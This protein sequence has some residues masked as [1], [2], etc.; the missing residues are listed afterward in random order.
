[1]PDIS[2][3]LLIAIIV[4]AMGLFISGK[5]RVDIIAL[6]VLLALLLLGLIRTDQALHGFTNPATATI[7]AIFIVS[8]GLARTGLIG[9]VGRH[10]DRL[11]GKGESRLILVLCLVVAVLSAFLVNTAVG[12]LNH[13]DPGAKGE[14]A[15]RA[16]FHA[17]RH[18]PLGLTVGAHGAFAN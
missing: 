5:I 17:S 4:I 1:M 10:I 13:L 7:A 3:I 14:S 2:L 6:C 9:W 12:L 15:N 18:F 16:G 8:A 11:A